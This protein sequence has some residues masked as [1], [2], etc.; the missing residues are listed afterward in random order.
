MKQIY[1]QKRTYKF[2]LRDEGTGDSFWDCPSR[3][4]YQLHYGEVPEDTV[5]QYSLR[6]FLVAFP[7]TELYTNRFSKK[8]MMFNENIVRPDGSRFVWNVDDIVNCGVIDKYKI[9][10]IKDVNMEWL[11]KELSFNQYSELVFD[12]EQSLKLMMGKE[13]NNEGYLCNNSYE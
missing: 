9:Y 8:I 2:F 10:D 11:S 7:E 12:R 3:V 13:E 6:E 1:R 5:Q 4:Y